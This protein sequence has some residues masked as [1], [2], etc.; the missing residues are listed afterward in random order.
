MLGGWRLGGS[1]LN[2]AWRQS[3]HESRC[4]YLRGSEGGCQRNACDLWVGIRLQG[5]LEGKLL[6]SRQKLGVQVL[7]EEDM[8]GLSPSYSAVT[9]SSLAPN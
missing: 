6:G 5:G 2:K 4:L 8:E 7:G 9:R 1:G 3:P